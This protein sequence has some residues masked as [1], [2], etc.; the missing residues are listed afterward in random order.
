MTPE[1]IQPYGAAERPPKIR[2]KDLE[3]LVVSRMLRDQ[4]KFSYRVEFTAATHATT[5]A[6]IHIQIPCE[7]CTHDGQVVP[8]LAYPLFIRVSKPSGWVV[9]T[10]ELTADMATHDIRAP[11]ERSFG[12]SSSPGHL[13]ACD[14]GQECD[15]RSR[16]HSPYPAPDIDLL[17]KGGVFGRRETVWAFCDGEERRVVSL[18]GGA[19]IA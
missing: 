14:C 19:V 17:S 16:R 8:S 11:S 12:R 1:S 5:L 13:S 7:A 15:H 6:R 9:D 3:A 2:F 4:V 18:E 10:S